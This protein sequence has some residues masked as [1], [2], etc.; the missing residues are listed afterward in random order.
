MNFCSHCAAPLARRHPVTT[1]HHGIALSDDYAW[2]RAGNWQEVM[3]DPSLLDGEIRGYL[4]AENAY[5]TSELAGTRAT[6][7]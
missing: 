2:L 7:G 1:Q 5:M 6:D 4:E 3:R